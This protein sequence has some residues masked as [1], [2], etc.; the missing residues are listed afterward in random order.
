MASIIIGITILSDCVLLHN[1][2]VR[3]S[4]RAKLFQNATPKSPYGVCAQIEF[5]GYFLHRL[6]CAD[7]GQ[8][9]K[10]T[11]GEVFVKRFF[12]I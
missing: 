5:R 2:S 12:R 10:L 11:I 8:Y 6:S 7:H 1:E 3:W 4:L 9:L